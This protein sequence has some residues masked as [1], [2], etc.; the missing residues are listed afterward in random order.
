MFSSRDNEM[1]LGINLEDEGS[2]SMIRTP[3]SLAS[4]V[5]LVSIWRACTWFRK[6]MAVTARS[7][8]IT[9]EDQEIWETYAEDEDSEKDW[10]SE[11]EDENGT[12]CI[13]LP[14]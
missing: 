4:L 11:E 8:F 3:D 14:L 10:N 1:E 9:E 12:S 13:P 2:M 7:V 6:L 5:K